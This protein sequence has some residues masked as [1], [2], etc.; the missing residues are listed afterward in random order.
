MPLPSTVSPVNTPR[1]FDRA[2]GL[3]RLKE[4]ANAA[5]HA[6]Q[7][8][9]EQVLK[10]LQADEALLDCGHCDRVLVAQDAKGHPPRRLWRCPCTPR[11][12]QRVY[13]QR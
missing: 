2:T 12:N 4:A 11:V 7:E 9:R 1:P 5:E 13:R 3:R 8:A 10:R 6:W